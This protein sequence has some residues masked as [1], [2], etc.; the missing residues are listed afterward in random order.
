MNREEILAKSKQ[1]NRG[2]DYVNLEV[3]KNSMQVGWLVLLLLLA[4]AMVVNAVTQSKASYEIGFAMLT[5][6]AVIFGYKYLKLHKKH[7]LI[8][9]VCY[10]LGAIG[11]LAGWIIQL[12]K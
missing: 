11:F 1:E 6:C 10:G 3:S 8:F 4:L 9:T 12:L 7:E 5:G 2:I